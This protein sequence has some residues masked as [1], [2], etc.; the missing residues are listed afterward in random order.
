[1]K[2]MIYQATDKIELLD[3]G[4]CEGY[5]YYILNLGT[6]PTAYVQIP[7]NHKYYNKEYEEINLDVHGGITYSR[8]RLY[9]SKEEKIDGWFIGWDYAHWGDYTG[10]EE[11]MPEEC[12]T[13]GKKWTTKEIQ[14]EVYEACR[15]LKEELEEN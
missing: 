8:N 6:H 11:N 13:R 4:T 3:T 14:E 2:E 7:E 10:Y 5:T 12:K 15:Q 1:M 9:L